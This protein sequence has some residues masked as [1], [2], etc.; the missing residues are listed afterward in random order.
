[1]PADDRVVQRAVLQADLDLLAARFVHGLLHGN[2]HLT[3]LALTHADATV[4]VT[5]HG[6]RGETEDPAALHHLGD[7]V[8]RHHLF[9]HTVAAVFALH[10][11]LHLRHFSYSPG[12][13]LEA[14]GAGR[15]GKGLD[16]AVITV[17]AAVESDRLDA[18]GFRFLR[19][20]LTDHFGRFDVSAMLELRA[21]F[22]LRGGGARKNLG[23]VARGDLRV[24]V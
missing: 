12:L 13:E 4:A 3:R 23:S 9:A 19:N 17:A 6:E 8:D 5:N 15:V 11:G 21:H 18:C 24:D 14:A 20:A 7:A 2:R 16:T 10:P 1:M 22:L